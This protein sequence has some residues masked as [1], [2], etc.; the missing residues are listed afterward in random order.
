MQNVNLVVLSG[1]IHSVSPGA[2]HVNI[3]IRVSNVSKG[4]DGSKIYRKEN[5]MVV[6]EDPGTI[7]QYLVRG[8][9]VIVQGCLSSTGYGEAGNTYVLAKSVT[10]NG[11]R[12][13]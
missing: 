1:E 3:F 4:K 10:F 2:D 11:A 7:L 6:M 8:K 5:I 13:D 12:H 9:Y